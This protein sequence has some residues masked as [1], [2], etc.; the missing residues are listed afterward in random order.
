MLTVGTDTFV[1]IDDA[2]TYISEY[3]MSNSDKYKAW[4]QLSNDDK[5]ICLREACQ[6]LSVLPYRGVVYEAFQPLP[7]PRFMG[8]AWV[9][10]YRELIAPEAILYPEMQE[11]PQ[12]IISAQIEEALE[13]ICP[14]SDTEAFLARNGAVDSYTIGHLSE[15][16]SKDAS[17]TESVI[18]SLKAQELLKPFIGGIYD[19]DG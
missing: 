12:S 16:Y 11:I 9:M 5:E 2:N 6:E 19:I 7:F 14:S 10:A 4:S 3:Y 1:S 18:R 13:L 17:A 15:H 8:D